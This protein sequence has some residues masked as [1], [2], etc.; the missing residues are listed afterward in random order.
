MPHTIQVQME[1]ERLLSKNF[2]PVAT[3]ELEDA[4]CMVVDVKECVKHPYLRWVASFVVG[5]VF[6][7][8]MFLVTIQSFQ[9]VLIYIFGAAEA[10]V[11]LTNLLSEWLE[12]FMARALF[13]S[14]QCLFYTITRGYEEKIYKA[15]NSACFSSCSKT[16][17]RKS[18]FIFSI[19]RTF[20][21]DGEFAAFVAYDGQLWMAS[22]KMVNHPWYRGSSAY[23]IAVHVNVHV[24]VD[25]SIAQC[26]W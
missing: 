12:H 15:R 10:S 2:H 19:L 21:Q 20:L 4:D 3:E 14:V 8:L 1:K 16:E 26:S 18:Y 23:N 9:F 24:Y 17:C 22:P 5:L 13:G 6:V 25:I 7:G 11:Q